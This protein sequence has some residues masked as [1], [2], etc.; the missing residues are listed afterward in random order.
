M[1]RKK[2]RLTVKQKRLAEEA[3]DLI[4]KAI[5]GFEK[6]FPGVREKLSK[7]DAV[8]VANLAIVEAA[9]TYDERKSKPTTY[10]TKAIV[11][12]LLKELRRERRFRYASSDRVTLELA[13]REQP[14]EVWK[15][16]LQ[17]AFSMLTECQRQLVRARYV[18]RKTFEEMADDLGCDRRTVRRRLLEAIDSLRGTSDSLADE[19]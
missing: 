12:A 4:P 1:K 15:S 13:E 14:C 9:R 16:D 3:I 17:V 10:F 2:K 18:D 6:S 5:R 7:V 19:Q 8:S 11:H